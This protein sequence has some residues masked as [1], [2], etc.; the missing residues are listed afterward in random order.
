MVESRKYDEGVTMLISPRFPRSLSRHALILYHQIH[1]FF[2]D[3]TSSKNIARACFLHAMK[4]RNKIHTAFQSLIKEYENNREIVPIELCITQVIRGKI[5]LIESCLRLSLKSLVESNPHLL[6]V[7]E[8]VIRIALNLTD[9]I[10]CTK[11]CI[12]P[13]C[14][15]A[16]A[17]IQSCEILGLEVKVF[18]WRKRV[19]IEDIRRCIF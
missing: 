8:A 19:L 6:D 11:Y 7:R 2:G 18:P 10:Y 1:D 17:L 3:S 13:S 16:A 14:A 4:V 9:K 5:I 12:Y 15:A